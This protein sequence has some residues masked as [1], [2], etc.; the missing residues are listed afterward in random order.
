VADGIWS[1]NGP[2]ND[3]MYLVVG[4]KHAMLVDTGMGIGDLAATVHGLTDLPVLVV[5][6][7]GH[8]DHAGGN[9]NFA[10]AWLH[11]ADV[12]IMQRMC[13][14]EFRRN[15]I[16]AFLGE[17][18]P[19]FQRF[20]SALVP[21]KPYELLSLRQGQE[22]D[23]GGRQF[24][25]VEVPGHTP[26]GIGLLCSKEKI[27]FTGDSIVAT[28][29]WLYLKHSLPVSAYLQALERLAQR[30]G[31]F[32]TLFPGHNPLPLDV[33]HLHELI[34]CAQQIIQD[35][36]VGE[37]TTTFAGHGLQVGYGRV[38]IIYNP[39]NVK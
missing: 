34:H 12:P 17:T 2:S 15:D 6:T 4:K 37:P 26:G 8:P 36:G 32:T 38:T 27:L 20:S 9:S 14:D 19:D 30:E 31:E 35:P 21:N 22:F 3:L 25:V 5:N 39:E 29:V 10:H 23:L 33:N 11:P 28:P 24:E 7:H 13:T 1:I 18:H 16:K